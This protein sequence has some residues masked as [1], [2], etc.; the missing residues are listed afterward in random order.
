[1]KFHVH[2]IRETIFLPLDSYYYTWKTFEYA[3]KLRAMEI[4]DGDEVDIVEIE[5]SNQNYMLRHGGITYDM[6]IDACNK[7]NKTIDVS[8]LHELT[9]WHE[10]HKNTQTVLSEAYFAGYITP[11]ICLSKC[12]WLE[13]YHLLF[14]LIVVIVFLIVIM[15]IW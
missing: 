14:S 11:S 3:S 12:L 7:Y 10:A 1:M 5:Q 8:Y 6:L 4:A 2:N 15:F 13:G 9:E